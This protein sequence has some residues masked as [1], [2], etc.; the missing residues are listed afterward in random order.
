M[1]EV[2]V[3]GKPVEVEPGTTVLQVRPKPFSYCHGKLKYQ[4]DE[5]V[6]FPKRPVRRQ[7]FR[8]PDSVTTSDCQ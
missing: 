5:Y 1:V 7:E 4:V 2:F 8:S 6:C 3:D